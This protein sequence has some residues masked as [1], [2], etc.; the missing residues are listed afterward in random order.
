MSPALPSLRFFALAVELGGK[1]LM[2]SRSRLSVLG[3]V[4][5]VGGLMTL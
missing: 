1:T 2:D 3:D 5:R 4:G